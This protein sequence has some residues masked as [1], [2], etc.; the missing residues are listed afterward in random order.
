MPSQELKDAEYF[1]KI[2]RQHL[3]ELKEKYSVNYLGVFG[4]YIRGE[5]TEDSDLDI[6]VQFDKKPGLFKYIE[7]EDHLSELLGVKVDLVMK[8]ALKPNIGKRIL[9]EV[10]V[11]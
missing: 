1:M 5:Q 11:V 2:L 4:S 8:S 6:L 9:S 10:E 7:L 3:P